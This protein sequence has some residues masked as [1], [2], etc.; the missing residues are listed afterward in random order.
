MIS[1]IGSR[2]TCGRLEWSRTRTC[3]SFAVNKKIA[4]YLRGSLDEWLAALGASSRMSLVY[5]VSMEERISTEDFRVM[6]TASLRSF[7]KIVHSGESPPYV[8]GPSC[9]PA[10]QPMGESYGRAKHQSCGRE[11]QI[12]KTV[13]A[14]TKGH[15]DVTMVIVH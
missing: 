1:Q 7:R 11:S 8:I 4:A 15:Q 13:P 6:L 10:N 3:S 2:M 5:G 9:G 14:V 12:G